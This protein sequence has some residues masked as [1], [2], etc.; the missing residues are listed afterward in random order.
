MY[1]YHGNLPFRQNNHLPK[2]DTAASNDPTG[3]PGALVE[4]T[5]LVASFYGDAESAILSLS[6]LGAGSGSEWASRRVRRGDPTV[7]VVVTRKAA[8]QAPSM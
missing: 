2:T 1:L 4:A 6:E 7:V 5:S 8:Q 3:R